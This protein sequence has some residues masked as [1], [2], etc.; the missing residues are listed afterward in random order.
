MVDRHALCLDAHLDEGFFCG[1]C[2]D[3]LDDPH[4]CKD[5][6][7]FCLSCITPWLENN[8]SCPICRQELQIENLAKMRILGNMI[9]KLPVRCPESRDETK[10]EA[11][12]N[13]SK[14]RGLNS[15]GLFCQWTG[16]M[17]ELD[18]HILD[19]CLFVEVACPNAASGCDALVQRQD[20]EEHK[21]LCP[22]EKIACHLCHKDGILH[23]DINTH[24]AVCD[25]A[26]ISCGNGCG[27]LH[28]RKDASAHEQVC[29]QAII[30]CPFTCF[31]CTA[32]AL[33]RAAYEQHQV[34]AAH[35][36]T[37]LLASEVKSLRD[38]LV[39]PNSIGTTWKLPKYKSEPSPEYTLSLQGQVYRFHMSLV[40]ETDSAMRGVGLCLTFRGG[41]VSS[42][43]G[44]C[45]CLAGSEFSL[46]G[47][48]AT[49]D[50]SA[51]LRVDAGCG[52]I[53]CSGFMTAQE[54]VHY[55]A[56]ETGV[57]IRALVILSSCPAPPAPPR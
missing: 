11:D 26:V 29:P 37:E 8:S 55:S 12:P 34:A 3:V 33:P 32:G 22:F 15:T 27:T 52:S 41:G 9:A 51:V 38:Q 13:R 18:H 10:D 53:T 30:E 4:Q 19:K 28:T 54:W 1:I 6:H 16:R 39:F 31:G 14:K 43:P 44:L 17:A 24:L 25:M 46:L 56:G 36:H 2:A 7:A 57:E 40:D 5:G 45:L 20:I 48:T 50:T 35:S 47:R 42:P 49:L 23:K 21:Q